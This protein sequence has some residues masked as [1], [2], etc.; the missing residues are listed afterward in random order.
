MYPNA[1]F[2]TALQF[3]LQTANQPHS[4]SNESCASKIRFPQNS[5]WSLSYAK[6]WY[7]FNTYVLVIFILPMI[8]IVTICYVYVYL[9]AKRHARAINQVS[10]TY[11]TNQYFKAAKIILILMSGWLFLKSIFQVERATVR[12]NKN[13]LDYSLRKDSRTN[14]TINMTNGVYMDAPSKSVP[15]ITNGNFST[16]APFDNYVRHRVAKSPRY[17][18]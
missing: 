14:A 1:N 10:S 8:L 11:Q 15:E 2:W 18:K 17:T 5:C 9:V 3:L 12:I 6:D 16:M 7:K 4:E 13:N